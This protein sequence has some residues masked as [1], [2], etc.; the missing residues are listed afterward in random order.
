MIAFG[1][2][3][4]Y[5]LMNINNIYSL[6]NN[7]ANI[8]SMWT[9]LKKTIKQPI[10]KKTDLILQTKIKHPIIEHLLEKQDKSIQKDIDENNAAYIWLVPLLSAHLL[11]HYHEKYL[12]THLFYNITSN[13]FSCHCNI[14]D[15]CYEDLIVFIPK[16]FIYKAFPIYCPAI[17]HESS[18]EI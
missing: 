6:L 15:S 12:M 5:I 1:I 17:N 7:D 11:S 18:Y 8:N 10:Q 4:L 14:S 9:Q 2:V 13:E 16:S 3:L